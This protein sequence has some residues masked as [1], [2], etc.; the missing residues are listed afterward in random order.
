MAAALASSL[1]LQVVS[2]SDELLAPLAIHAALAAA[3]AAAEV[4]MAHA[5]GLLATG[6]A[7]HV[8]HLQLNLSRFVPE[9]TQCIQ[10]YDLK[11]DEVQLKWERS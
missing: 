10:T 8:S 1:G 3:A 11:D 6:R 2:A 9:T 7:S 4:A 5:G